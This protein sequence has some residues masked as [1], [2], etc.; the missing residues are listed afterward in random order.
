L[1]APGRRATHGPVIPRRDLDAAFNGR[2][3][4]S[5][6]TARVGEE[7][8]VMA[9]RFRSEIVFLVAI[10]CIGCTPEKLSVNREEAASQSFTM[11]AR[12]GE[13][14]ERYSDKLTRDLE[15]S[16]NTPINPRFAYNSQ[17]NTCIA[18]AGYLSMKDPSQSYKFLVDSLTGVT[19]FE[20]YGNDQGKQAEFNQTEE[21]LMGPDESI[22]S[23]PSAAR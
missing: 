16:G 9:L 1:R 6:E 22:Q 8:E 19:L 14:G 4:C 17:L 7:I 13:I 12:C 21:R 23:R 3:R 15:H 2:E 10:L 11:K 5:E 18:S 20:M